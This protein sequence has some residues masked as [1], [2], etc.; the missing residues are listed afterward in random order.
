MGGQRGEALAAEALL[1]G[2]EGDPRVVDP[3]L[4]LEGLETRAFLV[5]HPGEAL[6]DPLVDLRVDAAHEEAR[7]RG[8]PIHRLSPLDPPL[9]RLEPGVH[10]LVVARHG[11]QQ[12][13]VDV[14]AIGEAFTDGRDPRG[15]ARD[16][17]HEVRAVDRVPEAVGLG[18]RGVGVPRD[19]RAH[20][21][22][23]EAV[24]SRRPVVDRTEE[25]RR[26]ADILDHDRIENGVRVRVGSGG[27][28]VLVVEVALRDRLLEDR[29]IGGLAG[30]VVLADQP[31]LFAVLQHVAPQVVEPDA[32]AKV[33]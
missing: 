24:L 33:V 5:R 2:L 13:D 25:S 30:Q 32:L 15:G 26:R 3:D 23:D 17:D 11:E 8:Q 22:G 7:H 29:G 21:D 31:G 12:R 1:V 6:G 10:H 18:D 20:L 4:S 16:L 9:H 19:I 28:N 14:D 27:A